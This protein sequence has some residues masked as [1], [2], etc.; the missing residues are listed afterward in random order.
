LTADQRAAWADVSRPVHERVLS[1]VGGHGRAIYSAIL[2]GKRA[3]A[4]Q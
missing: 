1:E 4:A 3:F 2:E